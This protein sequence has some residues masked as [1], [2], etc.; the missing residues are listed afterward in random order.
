[1]NQLMKLKKLKINAKHELFISLYE[2]KMN[3]KTEGSNA[4][5]SH[6]MIP[7]I[8][9]LTSLYMMAKDSA[10]KKMEEIFNMY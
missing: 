9:L 8:K 3:D 5:I 2:K 4:S 1:M 7:L 10:D 6:K